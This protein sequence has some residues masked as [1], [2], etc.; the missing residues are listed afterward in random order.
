MRVARGNML[1]FSEGRLLSR[2][3]LGG[4]RRQVDL[5]IPGKKIAHRAENVRAFDASGEFREG[6]V[7]R[8][9]CEF[10]TPDRDEASALSGPTRRENRLPEPTTVTNPPV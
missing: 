7:W 10:E 2:T 5:F 6:G 9:A 3:L 8:H 1:H 4:T